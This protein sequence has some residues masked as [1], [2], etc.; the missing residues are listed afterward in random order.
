MPRQSG[1]ELDSFPLEE[2]WAAHS[3]QHIGRV[4]P[5]KP[6]QIKSPLLRG[7][8]LYFMN[9]REPAAVKGYRLRAAPVSLCCDWRRT[10]DDGSPT[11]VDYAE[12]ITKIDES[13]LLAGNLRH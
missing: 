12:W 10:L 13:K 8:P 11:V 6:V 7:S 9:Q 4:E 5:D 3:P 1:S 2:E